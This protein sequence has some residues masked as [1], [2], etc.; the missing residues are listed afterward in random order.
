MPWSTGSTLMKPVPPRRPW[1]NISLQVA[2]HRVRAV[3]LRDDA[4]D[5]VRPRQVKERAV[6]RLG[7][8]LE[9]GRRIVTE[10]L[11]DPVDPLSCCHCH[12]GHIPLV[13]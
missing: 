10:E 7:L 9:E 6:D 13:S 2:Q 1:S 4:V 5:E 3:A 11:R 8:V 12:F